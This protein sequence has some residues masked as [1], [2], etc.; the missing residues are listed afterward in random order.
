MP[1]LH[2]EIA[3]N[4][5]SS[6]VRKHLDQLLVSTGTNYA[7]VIDGLQW[8]WEG[9]TLHISFFAY[10]FSIAA[11]VHVGPQMLVWDG[12]IPARATFVCGK[13]QRTIQGKLS[14]MLNS[15]ARTLTDSTN[16]VRGTA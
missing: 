7:D 6:T 12:Y 10:G 13:I 5:D 14:E 16:R 15:C 11:D 4:I 3:H 2:S 9:D 1:A 8:A